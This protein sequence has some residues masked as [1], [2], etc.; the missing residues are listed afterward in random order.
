MTTT[1]SSS[2]GG[3]DTGGGGG[4]TGPVCGDGAVE[5]AEACDDGNT[6]DGDGCAADCAIEAGFDCDGSPS[7]CVEV[8]GD[9]LVV[10]AEECDDSATDDGDGCSAI[11]TVEAG[12]GCTGQPSVCSAIC[13][14]GLVVDAEVCDDGGSLDG[15]GCS[16]MCEPETGFDCD[17]QMPTVC[18]AI[19]GDGLIVG[20]ETCDDGAAVAGDGCD[21]TCTEEL[22]YTC[23][24]EPSVCVTT[25]GDG[26]VAGTELCDDGNVIDGDGCSS[27]CTPNTGESC[28]DPL[29]M[30][31]GTAIANG[32]TWTV[33]AGAVTQFDGTMACDPT[34]VGPDVV[35]AYVK[36]TDTVANG[37]QLLHI[38]AD[39]PSSTSTNG[40]LDVEVVGGACDVA[41]GSSLKCLWY[42]DN[43]DAYLDVP[44][45]TYYIWVAKNSPATASQPFP[46][47]T[48]VAEEIPPADAEGEGCFAPYDDASAIYTPPATAGEPHTWTIGADV[49]SFD[50]G[51]TWGEPT[52]ISCDN[53]AGYGDIHGVDAVIEYD[54][55]SPTSVLL[56]EVQNLDPT[57]SQSDLNLEILNVCDTSNPAKASRNCRA[58]RDTISVTAPSPAGSVYLWLS[59]EATGEELNGASV[60]V[61]EIFPGVGES[62]PTAQPLAGSGPISPTSTASY[63]VPS[64]FPAM[65]AIHWYSYTLVNDAA[66]ITANTTGLVA[67]Y[68]AG[69]QEMAC[70][71]DATGGFGILGAPGETY[72][73]AVQ[74]PSPISAF[75]ISDVV[76]NGV[77]SA[78]VDM[79][80]T[81][82]SSA[83][84]E[85]GMAVSA[86]ELFMGDTSSIFSMPK[87]VGASAVEHG[88][89]EGLT[90]THLGYDL[91]FTGGSLFSADSTSTTTVS[92]LFRV[93]DGATWGPTAWD[94][95][96]VYPAS[97][98]THAIATDGTTLFSSTR[99]TTA[100]SSANFYSFS[101]A[102]ASTPTLLGT[103]TSVWYVT[104]MAA[105]STY[106][107]VASNGTQG[108]GIYRIERANVAGAAVK[109]ANINTGINCNNI[110]LDSFSAPQTLYARDANGS[111]HAVVQPA[112][113]T[114]THIGEI[115][116]LG[117]TSDYA[118]TFDQATGSLYFFETETV[119]AGRILR[120]D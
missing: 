107:Y 85:F 117:T 14:D 54:K 72:T 31:Q 84:G 38:V 24:G 40:Y 111:I 120:I 104:G 64:C 88:T 109:L 23:T 94:Q 50:M 112:S 101:P 19:C 52:S 68:D 59:S 51:A 18:T 32:V 62:W 60:E 95:T 30:S 65:G 2:A 12:Y 39:T 99:R 44:A 57:L 105:D 33:P 25:C 70:G 42:K 61:T 8:C 102:A 1:S 76:Y 3:G 10:G 81:F 75:T 21:D 119:S 108:E 79:Q 49:N 74:S 69:G 46:E 56:V 103:N 36:T 13:G 35:V 16:A 106:F 66:A 17:M 9:G 113:A 27:L 114:P 93:Y 22:G 86:T 63:D 98:P 6:T 83:L 92:R 90:T 28:A 82:P 55:V 97:S 4:S 43:W 37:G 45:G 87:T 34:G 78:P 77:D 58:N 110:E 7:V 91:V 73:I 20:T 26:I 53:T 15:D 48:I 41:S 116:S 67:I 80:I 71:T 100:N 118:M 5:G 89:A 11:C 47:V 96:P 115:S 29:V